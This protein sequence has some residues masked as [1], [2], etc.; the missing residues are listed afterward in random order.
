MAIMPTVRHGRLSA[1][2]VSFRA[3]EYPYEI[4]SQLIRVRTAIDSRGRRLSRFTCPD[5]QGVADSLYLAPG[6]TMLVCRRCARVSYHWSLARPSGSDPPG[7]ARAVE[8]AR[9]PGV[10][11]RRARRSASSTL[12]QARSLLRACAQLREMIVNA[13]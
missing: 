13:P 4:Y 10:V 7:W 5:C 12:Q 11:P 1:V 2:A 8:A 9:A 6:E 3:L